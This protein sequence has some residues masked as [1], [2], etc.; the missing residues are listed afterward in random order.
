MKNT[1]NWDEVRLYCFNGSGDVDGYNA[2]PGNELTLCTQKRYNHDVYCIE[3]DTSKVDKVVF[4]NKGKGQQSVDIELS[5][6]DSHN[7]NGCSFKNDNGIKVDS[8][9]TIP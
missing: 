8:Y 5:W 3:I 1:L 9:F 4:N 7:A 6:F 2:W